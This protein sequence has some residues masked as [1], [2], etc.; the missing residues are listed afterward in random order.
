MSDVVR[1]TMSVFMLSESGSVPSSPVIQPNTKL[2]DTIGT[3]RFDAIAFNKIAKQRT[4]VA[5]GENLLFPPAEKLS[6]NKQRVTSFLGDIERRYRST[7]AYHNAIH[8]TDVLSGMAYLLKMKELNTPAA[9]FENIE[10]LAALTAA[11][12]HDVGHNGKSNRFQVGAG[13]PMSLLFNDQSVLE[14]M[15]C[16]LTFM[17]LQTD[18]CNFIADLSVSLRAA[19]R[20]TVVKM[21]LET[22]LAKHIESLGRFRHDF[23]AKALDKPLDA[24]QKQTLLSFALKTVDI[25]HSAKSFP[26]HAEWTLRITTELFRQG[27]HE[28][29][30]GIPCSPFCDRH[31]TVIA[32]SQ[33][34]FFSFIAMPLFTALDEYMQSSKDFK[35]NVRQLVQNRDFWKQYDGSGLTSSQ[36]INDPV[37]SV[38][39]LVQNFTAFEEDY[40]ASRP[41]AGPHASRLVQRRNS[42]DGAMSPMAS[43]AAVDARK[44]RRM[45]RTSVRSVS[46]DGDLGKSLQGMIKRQQSQE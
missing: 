13:T 26:L 38:R 12:G 25:G 42:A 11:T 44:S 23:L 46:Q 31:S 17:V 14:S 21:I 1:T 18:A 35:E 9:G 32:E 20:P 8:G 33:S 19:F 29:K 30:L 4:L 45:S 37:H 41:S 15:H 27:D 10:I 34:G 36:F 28:V 5:V 16:A 40:V 22:D 2:M 39:V 43:A 24:A 6:I 7:A 3:S